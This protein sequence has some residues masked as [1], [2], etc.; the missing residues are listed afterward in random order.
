ML[1]LCL[2]FLRLQRI[3]LCRFPFSLLIASLVLAISETESLSSLL[4]PKPLIASL[5]LAVPET[6]SYFFCAAF[7]ILIASL[8]LGVP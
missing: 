5:P 2:L 8:S 4:S 3:A 1:L 6:A 7:A